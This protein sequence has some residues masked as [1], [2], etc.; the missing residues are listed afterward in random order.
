[1]IKLVIFMVLIVAVFGTGWVKGRAALQARLDAQMAQAQTA[2]LETSKALAV[3]EQARRT[4]SAQLEDAANADPIAVP[5]C[6]SPGRV[7]RINAIR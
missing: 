3:A 7:R 1:V 2:A 5:E 6:L 4:L